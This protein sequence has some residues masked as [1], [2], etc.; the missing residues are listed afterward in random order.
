MGARSSPQHKR[1][2]GGNGVWVGCVRPVGEGGV[3]GLRRRSVVFKKSLL[4]LVFSACLKY[5]PSA[6]VVAYCSLNFI[7]TSFI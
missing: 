7:F 5:T 3:G 1:Q 6:V 4:L 2:N